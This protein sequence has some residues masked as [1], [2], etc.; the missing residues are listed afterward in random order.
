MPE[1]MSKT[2]QGKDEDTQYLFSI[3]TPEVEY[4]CENSY[5]EKTFWLSF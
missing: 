5:T 4:L 1:N 3:I 2:R